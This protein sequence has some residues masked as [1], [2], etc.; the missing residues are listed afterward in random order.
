ME[1]KSAN[2]FLFA[3]SVD[4]LPTDHDWTFDGAKAVNTPDGQGAIVQHEEH[5]Y[6]LN[7]DVGGCSWSILPQ[8]LGVEVRYAVA[9]NLPSGYT[10]CSGSF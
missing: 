2:N 1:K 4:A 9:F 3:I 7:C 10:T 5:F 8:K 6:Q